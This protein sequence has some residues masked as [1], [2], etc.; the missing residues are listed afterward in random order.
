[1]ELK[2]TGFGYSQNPHIHICGA[3]ATAD[4]GG[5]GDVISR[6]VRQFSE[7]VYK[8]FPKAG[9]GPAY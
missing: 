6:S 1:M 9:R 5:S 2:G 3:M 7:Y 4:A 8:H